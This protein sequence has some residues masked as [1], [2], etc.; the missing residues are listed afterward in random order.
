MTL[1]A[2]GTMLLAALLG[3]PPLVV[4][5][6]LKLRRKP[7]RVTSTMLWDQAQKDLEVNVPF[8][9]IRPSWL[10]ILHALILL[11][12]LIAIGRPAIED[13]SSGAGRV[14][15]LIDRSASMNAP[16]GEGPGTRLDA[17]KALARERI[18]AMAES[19]APPEVTVIAFA[20]EPVVVGPPAR[21][22]GTMPGPH[23][24]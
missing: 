23:T 18:D 22:A 21:D 5:Y 10:L 15:L 8:R 13:A 24:D 17:A 12:L 16:S 6:L 14:F 20:T 19:A 9:W 2:P 3:V 4:F 11:A 1:L 7:M